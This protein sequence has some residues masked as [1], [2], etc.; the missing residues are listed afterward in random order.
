MRMG[1]SPATIA[2]RGLCQTCLH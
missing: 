2:C 1:S